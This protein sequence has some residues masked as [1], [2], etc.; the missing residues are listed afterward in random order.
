MRMEKLIFSRTYTERLCAVSTK[1]T[2]SPNSSN[3]SVV[4]IL[5]VINC[6]SKIELDLYLLLFPILYLF[7]RKT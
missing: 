4:L 2:T 7:F 1:N 6:I 3:T 5:D